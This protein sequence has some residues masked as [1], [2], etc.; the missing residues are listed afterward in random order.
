MTGGTQRKKRRAWRYGRFA[1]GLSA[2][3]RTAKGYRILARGF[4]VPQG[5][6]DIVAR[7]GGLLVMVEVKARAT[8]ELAVQALGRRQQHRIRRAAEAFLAA[9]PGLGGLDV[10]FDAILIS[11]WRA[12][13]HIPGVWRE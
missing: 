9:R 12:P 4:R 1:E 7:R 13:R 6:I 3:F 8:A 11:P 10:R 2:W 5:E